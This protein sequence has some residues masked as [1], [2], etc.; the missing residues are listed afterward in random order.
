M[1][2]RTFKVTKGSSDNVYA[3]FTENDVII[4]GASLL[5]RFININIDEAVNELWY[6]GFDVEEV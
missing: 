6:D 4:A 3:L 2:P 5:Q 1:K